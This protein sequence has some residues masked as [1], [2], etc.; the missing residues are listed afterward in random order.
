[1]SLS[2]RFRRGPSDG[3]DIPSVDSSRVLDNLGTTEGLGA[4]GPDQVGVAEESEAA[5]ALVAPPIAAGDD[6]PWRSKGRSAEDEA[7][8]V[9]MAASADAVAGEATIV[10]EVTADETGPEDADDAVAAE[11]DAVATA[12]V[13]DLTDTEVDDESLTGAEVLDAAGDSLDSDEAV[14]A[15]AEREWSTGEAG[16][17]PW[18]SPMSSGFESTLESLNAAMTSASDTDADTEA[19]PAFEPLELAGAVD[20]AAE[21]ADATVAAEDHEEIAENSTEDTDAVAAGA[22]AAEAAPAAPPLASPA[23]GRSKFGA[24]KRDAG[25]STFETVPGE[26]NGHGGRDW[27][28]EAPPVVAAD[29]VAE[30]AEPSE[31]RPAP[32]GSIFAPSGSPAD[33]RATSYGLGD[34]SSSD[35][36]IDPLASLKKRVEDALLRRIGARLAE[37]EIKEEELRSFVERELGA[38]LIGE[39]TAL[40]KSEREVFVS[41]LTDD[42]LGHGPMEQFLKDESVTEVMVSGLEPMYVERKGRLELTDVRFTSEA[43]LRQVIERIVG[44]VGR[45]IDESSPMVDARLPDGSRVNAII[46]P[47]SVDG[48]ALTIRKF[49]QRALVVD[50][51]IKSGSLSQNAADMLSACVRGRLNILVTGGTGSGKTTMLNVL[52]SF[53]PDDQRIVTIEDA[54]ELRLSQHH[55][56]RLEARPPNIEG[57]GA[58]SIRELVRNSLRMRP[59]RIIVGEVRSGE[60]LDMLQAMNTGHDG[61]LSTLHANTPRDVLARLET[62]VLMAGFELPVRAIREQIASAVDLI[63]HIGR[64]RDG[65]RRVTHIVEVEGM[66]GEIITLT[67]LYLFDY[68]AGIDDDGRFKGQLKA[69]GLRPKFAE[70]LADQGIEVPLPSRG[71]D[72]KGEIAVPAGLG[73]GR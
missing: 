45:R 15:T 46:P 42:L 7:P 37:G 51:L 5:A 29:E 66:E 65:T 6:A 14:V 69:T 1:V 32:R 19:A 59:D 57:K 36:P 58:V 18:E 62:M 34:R 24:M 10:D 8:P 35:A 43:Q 33:G 73:W 16:F 31:E 61:S 49:S 50:D 41:R 20:E 4:V 23:F 3:E 63:V 64:L 70:R 52:S 25:G 60:A 48:P 2:D 38:V 55:V 17:K 9:E 53:I 39:Q 40:S 44:R 47:L 13:D 22:K 26:T 72:P 12:V 28:S 11:D 21:A 67:D 56:I 71:F 68:T 54:V 30:A 27:A